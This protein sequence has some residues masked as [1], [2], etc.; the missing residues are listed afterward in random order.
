MHLSLAPYVPTASAPYAGHQFYFSWLT[1]LAAAKDVVVVAPRTAD[2]EEALARGTLPFE[3]RLS[4]P[5]RVSASALTKARKAVG[6][7]R[8]GELEAVPAVGD[9]VGQLCRQASSM[10]L[11]WSE[12]LVLAEDLQVYG[13]PV[14]AVEYDLQW[15]TIV[16]AEGVLGRLSPRAPLRRWLVRRSEI[17]ALNRCA[18]ALVFKEADASTLRSSGFRGQTLVAS[19]TLQTPSGELIPQDPPSILFVGAFD[20]RENSEGARWFIDAVLPRLRAAGIPVRVILAGA[21]V[22]PD[23]ASLARNSGVETTGFVPDLD[24]VYRHASIAIAPVHRMGGLRF[25]VPQAMK[26]GLPVVATTEAW[27]GLDGAPTLPLLP[28]CDHPSEFADALLGLLGDPARRDAI[29]EAGREWVDARFSAGRTFD[30]LRQ[31]IETAED[32]GRGSEG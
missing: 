19:P 10:E 25:K 8:L 16:R 18:M 30:E 26:Y 7:L 11:N 31:W 28:P 17:A 5:R 24:P 14:F 6:I 2:N 22:Q 12:S 13:R 15:M 23:L 9:E 21:G 27:R 20:R 29:G 4:P 32:H 3:V 1:A